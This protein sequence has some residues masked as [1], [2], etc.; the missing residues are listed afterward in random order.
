MTLCSLLEPR[1][2][3][4]LYPFPCGK[5]RLGV[6]NI[7]EVV[8]DDQWFVFKCVPLRKTIQ[9]FQVR[10][11]KRLVCD[12]NSNI[13]ECHCQ[14]SVELSLVLRHKQPSEMR[15]LTPQ[16]Y[17]KGPHVV[18]TDA[19]QGLFWQGTSVTAD[20]IDQEEP[21]FGHPAVTQRARAPI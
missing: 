15:T 1:V 18:F 2:W 12:N 10:R 6:S 14:V 3:A 4:V 17:L 9:I 7:L 11:L 20:G 21:I 5:Q 13:S 19:T 16:R 8:H